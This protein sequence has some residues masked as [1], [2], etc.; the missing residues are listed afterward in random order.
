QFPTGGGSVAWNA[1]GTGFYYTRYPRGNERPKEDMTFYEQVYFHKLGTPT[2]GDEY[3]LGKELPRIA[4]VW[5]DSSADGRE[6]LVTVANG[7]GG[8]YEHFLVGPSGKPI[9]ITQFNDQ[10]TAMA[11]GPGNA[12]Y[13]VSLK[14]SPRGKILRLP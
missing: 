12:L 2:G 6:L 5:L 7:D 14:G 9:Q 10:V 1:D 3:I 8:E 11:F 4:E 13:L